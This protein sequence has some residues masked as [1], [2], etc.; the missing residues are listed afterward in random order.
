[1]MIDACE[2]PRRLAV[3]SVDEDGGWHL[4]MTLIENAGVTELRFTQH[5]TGTEEVGEI[6][7]GWEYYL[8]VLVAARDGEPTPDFDDY[9]PAMKEHFEAQR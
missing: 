4:D 3:S 5:L 9:Y 6:G 1:M 8:D 7:P 2:P